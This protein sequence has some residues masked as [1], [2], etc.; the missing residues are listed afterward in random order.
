MVLKASD[1][2]LHLVDALNQ[3]N[4]QAQLGLGALINGT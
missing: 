1:V 4:L 3:N 2:D